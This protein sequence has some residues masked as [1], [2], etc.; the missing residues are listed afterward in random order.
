[1][2]HNRRNTVL[3]RL[4]RE[5]R[6]RITA[7]VLEQAA[8]AQGAAQR[9]LWDRA[10]LLNMCV[11]RSIATRYRSRGIPADDLEQ[12]AQAALVRTVQTFD[13]HRERD[14]LSYAVPCIRGEL[15]RY[16][17]DAGWTVR[18]PRRIQEMQS[19]VIALRDAGEEAHGIAESLC[20]SSEDVREA[21]RAEGCFRPLS[22]DA[23]VADGQ[24]L[25]ERLVGIDL[26]AHDAAEARALLWG[27]L[28]ELPPRDRLVI[29]LRYFED[30]SQRE[31]A[32][33]LGVTQAQISRLLGRILR[34]LR[35][36]V[37]E[38]AA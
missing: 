14:L 1:M 35:G 21:L 33:R 6:R 4:P 34:D 20:A 38:I 23:G 37:G 12:V 36:A 10:V 32:D 19:Q 3:D 30:H 7:K 15:R 26:S 16:F 8:Q 11:A 24:N 27:P 29:W 9:T 25:G 2:V 18:P 13:V 28:R 17:R 22:L 31:I 5:H